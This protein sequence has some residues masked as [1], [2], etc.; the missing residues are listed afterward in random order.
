[1]CV[2]VCVRARMRVRVYVVV[3]LGINNHLSVSYLPASDFEHGERW[4]GGERE[5]LTVDAEHIKHCYGRTCSKLISQIHPPILITNN[6]VHRLGTHTVQ[7]RAGV[8]FSV[9]NQAHGL[10]SVRFEIS[11]R[12]HNNQ[13]F[14][15]RT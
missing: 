10:I 4:R 13:L 12:G 11:P 15:L 8:S 2:C 1:M 5:R 9:V 14:L 7:Q 6:N 3:L